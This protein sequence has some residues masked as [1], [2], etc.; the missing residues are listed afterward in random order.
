MN[1]E[2]SLSQVVGEFRKASE[3]LSSLDH[4]DGASET[5]ANKVRNNQ[6]WRNEATTEYLHNVAHEVVTKVDG[7]DK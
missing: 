1:R 4:T 3:V 2:D 5:R 6:G 7:H